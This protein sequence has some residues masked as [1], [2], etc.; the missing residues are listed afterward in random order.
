[1]GEEELQPPTNIKEMG[2]HMFYLRRD[3]TKLTE[4]FQEFTTNAV[5][6]TEFDEYKLE[7]TDKYIE[8]KKKVDRKPVVA[9]VL[10][11][12]FSALLTSLIIYM[13]T[14]ILNGSK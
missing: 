6:R 8:L 2:I 10:G 4:S 1:M 11:S 9:I 3:M 5:P 12:A 13:V 7:Q 14:D